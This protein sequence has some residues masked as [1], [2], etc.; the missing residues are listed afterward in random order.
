[1]EP[2]S[3]ILL[4]I[5]LCSNIVHCKCIAS[6]SFVKSK[7]NC[8]RNEKC[9]VYFFFQILVKS[10]NVTEHIVIQQLIARLRQST[11]EQQDLVEDIRVH[12]VFNVIVDAILSLWK[13][14]MQWLCAENTTYNVP[15]IP[16]T[17][18]TCQDFHIWKTVMMWVIIL[19]LLSVI[20]T[21]ADGCCHNQ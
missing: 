9:K 5:C 12:K 18:T 10:R 8:Q 4:I 16:P 17:P 3:N 11:W 14:C 21:L 6:N 15:V 2:L 7:K 20:S 19:M 13:N 1:M